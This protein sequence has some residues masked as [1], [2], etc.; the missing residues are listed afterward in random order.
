[1]P[2]IIQHH[3][4]DAPPHAIFKALTDAKTLCTWW[5][6]SATSD[7]NIGGEFQYEFHHTAEA[8]A[9]GKA[10]MVQEGKYVECDV[11]TI[12]YPWAVGPRQTTVRFV[13]NVENGGTDL[14]LVHSDVPDDEPT[15]QAL[16]EGWTFFLGNLANVLAGKPDGRPEAGLLV[17]TPGVSV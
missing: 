5:T 14:K 12:Q 1:M 13:L 4:F 8:L 10:D 9:Q 2:D 11:N 6:T 17:S 15:L 16:G 7:P 3:H